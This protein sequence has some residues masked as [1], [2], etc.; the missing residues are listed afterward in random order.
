ML[1]SQAHKQQS[2]VK[3]E[4]ISEHFVVEKVNSSTEFSDSSSLIRLLFLLLFSDFS[5]NFYYLL[6][7]SSNSCQTLG[8]FNTQINGRNLQMRNSIPTLLKRVENLN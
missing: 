1:L 4:L 2:F 7:F 3:L 6:F 5:T 8:K